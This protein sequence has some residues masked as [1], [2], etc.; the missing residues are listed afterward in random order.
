MNRAYRP[1][2][3]K[4]WRIRVRASFTP[5]YHI[6]WDLSICFTERAYKIHKHTFVLLLALA[7]RRPG[8]LRSSRLA[9][10]VIPCLHRCKY[11]IPKPEKNA[12]GFPFSP[13]YLHSSVEIHVFSN[14]YFNSKTVLSHSKAWFAFSWYSWSLKGK[15]WAKNGSYKPF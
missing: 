12:R 11:R 13:Q 6:S 2:S 14:I 8:S 10:S 7:N 1:I 3:M 15:P 5:H 4:N 9:T